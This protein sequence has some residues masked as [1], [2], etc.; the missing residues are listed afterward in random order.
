MDRREYLGAVLGLMGAACTDPPDDGAGAGRG[1]AA[2]A[3]PSA[4]P[5]RADGLPG[6][7]V[8]TD[9]ASA[10]RGRGTAREDWGPAFEAAWSSAAEVGTDVFVPAGLYPVRLREGPGGFAPALDLVQ[11]GKYR[12][13]RLLGGGRG[14]VLQVREWPAGAPRSLEVI[15]V[16]TGVRSAAGG[17]DVA[18]GAAIAGLTLEIRG[19]SAASRGW[20]TPHDYPGVGIR[21][22]GL[23]GAS[24][25]GCLIQGFQTGIVLGRD[26][27]EEAS[28]VCEVA[29]NRFQ[30]CN[31]AVRLPP[32]SNGHSV[33]GNLLLWLSQPRSGPVAAFEA[34]HSITSTFFSENSAEQC[35]VWIYGIGAAW[36][37]R[38]A[39]GRME[40]VAGV[41][42]VH[43]TGDFPARGTE[44]A[45]L[46]VDCDSLR[47]P[48]IWLE[49]SAGA[50]VSGIVFYQTRN[51]MPHVRVGPGA[52]RTS[53]AALES[54]DAPLR[55]EGP[56]AAIRW[57]GWGPPA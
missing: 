46:S 12:P 37:T 19:A 44:I 6:V 52:L 55:V 26:G 25:T 4:A 49:R 16:R 42:R 18:T 47:F 30:Y 21:L 31:R 2:E 39:G 8:V 51:A 23:Y 50:V 3:P 17:A 20:R 54:A 40:S 7:R 56:A 10:V 9:F 27:G 48:A 41:A 24:V 38:I 1:A 36:N 22:L 34:S 11:P 33:R 35:G 15:R 13:V 45:G 5:S 28:Y 43:G 53:L 32:T 57:T 29:G 14:A